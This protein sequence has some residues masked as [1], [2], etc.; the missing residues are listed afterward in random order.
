MK[1]YCHL[2]LVYMVE[3]RQH[4]ITGDVEVFAQGTILYPS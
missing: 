4:Y 3:N 2:K 1:I